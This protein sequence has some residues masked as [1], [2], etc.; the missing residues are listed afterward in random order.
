MA[1]LV[2]AH[3]SKSCGVIHESSILSPGTMQKLLVILGPT[4][5]GKSAL[6]VELAKQFNGEV[7]SA[8]SRQVYKG[9][10]IGTGKITKEEMQGI[11][12]HLLDVA[13]P[14]IPF[15]VEHYKILA[16]QAII[17][18][19]TRQKL[20]ILCGGTGFYISAV[21]DNIS[22]PKV[23]PNQELRKELEKETAETLFTQLQ[24]LD[25][26]R[27]EAIDSKNKVR[28]IRA[29]EITQKLGKVPN[30]DVQRLSDYDTLQIGL[31][32]PDEV[33]KKRIA[34]RINSRIKIG[35]IEEAQKFHSEELSYER[36]HALGLEYRYLAE[37]L[38][39]NSSKEEF[40]S[41]L[42]NEIWQYVKRQKTW[43]KKDPRIKWF[44]FQDHE[45]IAKEI[46]KFLG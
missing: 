7:I 37:L 21:V 29:I 32:V 33:L 15:S 27:A 17:D 34:D 14:K 45:K 8:D 26:R 39:N 40:V 4:A 36:M 13:D 6:A 43:F 28:L 42:N 12:H 16:E 30:L 41:K 24:K 3:D 19:F 11:P 44:D 25:S 20:P 31:T 1:E 5:S 22:L 46:E 23:P 2:D 10:D 18:I 35:M 38:Q 9:L